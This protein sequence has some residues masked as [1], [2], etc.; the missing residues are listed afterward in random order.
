MTL[1][2]V[3]D[4]DL[5]KILSELR[6]VTPKRTVPFQIIDAIVEPPV[7]TRTIDGASTVEIVL[8]DPTRT[9]IQSE[10]LQTQSW[11]VVSGLNFE[12]VAIAKNG[13]RITLTYEDAIVAQLR[14]QTK[15]LSVPA[16][17]T[18][19]RELTQRLAREARVKAVVDPTHKGKI[20]SAVSRST[21]NQKSNSWEMLGSDIAE[22]IQWRRFSDGQQLVVGGDQWLLNRDADVTRVTENEGPFGYLDFTLDVGR[23]ASEASIDV[24]AELW[25]L[26]PGSAVRVDGQGPADGRWL[27]SQFTRPLTSTRASVDLIRPRHTLKEPKPARG[28]SKGDRGEDGLLPGQQATG[29]STTTTTAPAASGAREKMV[30]FALAQNGDA[31]V[32]G[33]KG[34]SS[35]DCSGLV[36]G[37][38]AAAGKILYAPSSSQASAVANAGG[39][40]SIDAAIGTRGALL[41]RM[42]GEFNHVAISLGNGQTIEAM[43]TAYGVCYG[44]AAGRG[45]TSA[46]IWL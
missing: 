22:P 44:N 24:D 15:R 26:P 31:Y 34:P 25:S 23:P 8:S 21:K 19:R 17:T 27:V 36:Q 20:R 11:T 13:N 5:E 42:G 39:G 37:A 28:A 32:W 45:W 4:N 18:T 1:Q 2:Q 35:W 38:T 3:S 16:N 46:G 9:L 33:A 14:R 30:Q 29:T 7:L 12:L 6:F 43:G 40:M 41:F 10:V